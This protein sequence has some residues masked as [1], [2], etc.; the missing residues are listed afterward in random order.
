MQFVGRGWQDAEGVGVP[1]GVRVGDG[2]TGGTAVEM[3]AEQQPAMRS[4][5]PMSLSQRVG[6]TARNG[7]INP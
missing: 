2:D 4:L 7:S 1:L 3:Y 6:L 5:T